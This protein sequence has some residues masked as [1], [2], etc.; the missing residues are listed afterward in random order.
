MGEPMRAL[1]RKIRDAAESAIISAA[2]D[3][4]HD[5]IAAGDSRLLAEAAANA[6]Y[7]LIER[8]VR[9]EMA[10]EVLALDAVDGQCSHNVGPW[11]SMKASLNKISRGEPLP[12]W[13]DLHGGEGAEH[14]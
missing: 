14:G 9:R 10:R 6:V 4:G 1:S 2:T 12:D 7:P 3:F 8:E 11:G 13:R 5:R